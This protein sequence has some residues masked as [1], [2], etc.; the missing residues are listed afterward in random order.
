[1]RAADFIISVA[2]LKIGRAVV[3]TGTEAAPLTNLMKCEPTH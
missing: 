3:E 2:M 1:M